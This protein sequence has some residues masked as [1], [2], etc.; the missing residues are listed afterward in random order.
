MYTYTSCPRSQP[1]MEMQAFAR[2]RRWDS[3]G[4]DDL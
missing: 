1:E 2:W 4:M 3:A